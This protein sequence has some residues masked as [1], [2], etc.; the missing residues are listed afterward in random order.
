MRLKS[1]R[2]RAGLT[3]GALAEAV[4]K[5]AETIANIERGHS[6]TGVDTLEQIVSAVGTSISYFFDDFLTSEELRLAELNCGSSC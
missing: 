1:A 3:Q 5:A 6:L 4:G 2:Q